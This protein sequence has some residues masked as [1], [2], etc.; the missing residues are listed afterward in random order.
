MRYCTAVC[1]AAWE[2][3]MAALR[4]VQHTSLF[5]LRSGICYFTHRKSPSTTK[6]RRTR[7]G[8]TTAAQTLRASTLTTKQSSSYQHRKMCKTLQVADARTLHLTMP[9]CSSC[10][11]VASCADVVQAQRCT[12]RS[13]FPSCAS[14]AP[15]G[16]NPPQSAALQQQARC[17]SQQAS[18]AATCT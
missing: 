9:S 11:S 3:S 1:T 18:I 17:C 5:S 15:C 8:D 4:G 2:V 14:N 7:C 10:S 12:W 16:F 6:T 13:S